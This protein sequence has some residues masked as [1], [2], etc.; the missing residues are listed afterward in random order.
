MSR[1]FAQFFVATTQSQTQLVFQL[2]K[3][4][5]FPPYID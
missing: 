2:L 5:K 3:V 1:V 4:G